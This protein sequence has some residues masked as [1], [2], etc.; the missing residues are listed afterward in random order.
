MKP[1]DTVYSVSIWSDPPRVQSTEVLKVRKN[2][3]LH[4]KD[5]LSGFGYRSIIKPEFVAATPAEAL[6]KH[7]ASKRAEAALHRKKADE[8][9][10]RAAKAE[11]MA[12]EL[13]PSR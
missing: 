9:D 6:R 13:E 4:V 8:A 5:G 2:G 7:A 10:A 3:D 1:G 11:K 12:A